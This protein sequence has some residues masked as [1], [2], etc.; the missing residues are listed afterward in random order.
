MYACRNCISYQNAQCQSV[1]DTLLC[2]YV[3]V[4]YSTP[5]SLWLCLSVPLYI[6][7]LESDIYIHYIYVRCHQISC[8]NEIFWTS[9]PLP[10]E[11]TPSPPPSLLLSM[12]TL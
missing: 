7:L 1:S 12:Y 10:P 11:V 5:L 3:K 8:S 9:M 4:E 2:K 6:S